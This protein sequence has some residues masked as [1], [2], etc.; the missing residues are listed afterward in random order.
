V[1]RKRT[2]PA[3]QAFLDDIVAHPDDDAP[4]LVF[5]D[6]LEDRGEAARAEFIRL[7]CRLAQ[8]DEDD[9]ERT[10]LAERERELLH[11]YRG[12]WLE[13]W[14]AWTRRERPAFRR[15]FL[16][17]LNM[18]C[19]T[20]L[21]SARALFARGPL[22]QVTLR[23]CRGRLAEV[24]AQP[25]LARVSALT[26]VESFTDADVRALV[27]CPHLGRLRRL[28]LGYPLRVRD[29]LAVLA[30]WPGLAG[31]THL[32]LGG[33]SQAFDELP[34]LLASPHLTGLRSLG[35]TAQRPGPSVGLLAGPKFATLTELR[36]NGC[37]IEAAE[38][39]ALCGP[40]GLPN[41]RRL[42]LADNPLTAEGVAL[43]ARSPLLGRLHA[44]DLKRCDLDAGGVE[45][46]AAAGAGALRHLDLSGNSLGGAETAILA[47]GAFQ[48]LLE[49]DLGNNRVGADGAA[50]LGRSAG[51]PRLRSLVL[52]RNRLGPEAVA[53][54]TAGG[55]LPAL[56]HLDLESNRVAAGGA[57]SLA[58]WPGLAGVCV[59]SLARNAM[60]DDGVRALA[61]S[62]HAAGLRHLNLEYNHL[63]NKAA[64][65][66]AASPHLR[67]LRELSVWGNRHLNAKGARALAASPNLPHLLAATVTDLPPA[68]F[69]ALL[70]EHGKGLP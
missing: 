22:E 55:G 40:G 30:A 46:L 38:V 24:L 45:A 44:L 28:A 31:L 36:L 26:V 15:G 60:N 12:P 18:T 68:T 23:G 20:F 21:R 66:L 64:L 69:Q 50:A 48:G 34:A 11:A 53:A 25:C 62:P 5:A 63:S 41:L 37:L 51:L 9:P 58:G 56:T 61:G 19:G 4:R 35:L 8:L 49:L 29:T 13:G 14:P 33:Y 17:S 42:G 7:Q 59:L 52:A 2:P 47:A 39:R 65:A 6:W 1:A 32:S 70:R 27:A 54:L 16:A 57:R 10:D 67:S 43:L 3:E